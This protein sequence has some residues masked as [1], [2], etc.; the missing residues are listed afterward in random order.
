MNN[1]DLQKVQ[2]A[3]MEA[4][5]YMMQNTA[6]GAEH[7]LSSVLSDAIDIVLNELGR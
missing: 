7:R 3:L 6:E 2:L 5:M 4:D 1:Q